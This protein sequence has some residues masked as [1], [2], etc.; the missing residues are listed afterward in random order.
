MIHPNS[1]AVNAAKYYYAANYHD[2][3]KQLQDLAG[4]LVLTLPS[5]ADLRNEA[6]GATSASTCTPS[7]AS[8]SRPACGSTT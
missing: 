3:V 7:P 2:A 6:S 4:G 8:T 5:E 1:L